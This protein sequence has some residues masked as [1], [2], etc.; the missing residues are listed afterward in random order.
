MEDGYRESAQSW[1]ESLLRIKSQGLGHA[2]KLTDGEGAPGFWKTLSKMFSQTIPQRCGVHNTANVL[3][4]VSKLEQP[5]M[6]PV[7]QEIWMAPTRKDAFNAFDVA[8]L[9]IRPVLQ[10]CLLVAALLWMVVQCGCVQSIYKATGETSHHLVI[11]GDPHLPGPNLAQKK[12]VLEKIN[13]WDDVEMVIAVGDICSEYGTNEEYAAAR[14][15][16]NILRKPLLPVAGNHD[17]LYMTPSWPGGGYMTGSRLSQEA[18]LSTFRETFGLANYYYSREVGGYLLVFLSTDHESYATGIS[19]P[20]LNWL[21]AKLASHSQMPTIIFF[22]GPLK[23]T[24]R[25]FKRYVNQPQAIAQPEEAIHT[26][27]TQNPQ[28]FLWVSG[29]THTPPTEE[30]YA[31]PLNIYAGQVTNIHNPDMKHETIWTNSLYLYPDRVE[32]RTFDHQKNNWL[33]R[34]DRTI[35]SP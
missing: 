25:N 28:V 26:L 5:E 13:S 3:N 30:S 6:K 32:I 31:S 16:F 17:Y 2:L 1:S 23:G 22:H 20:Q 24:Q 12:R 34:L 8:L 7:L 35:K 11:L 33:P 9:S 21:R 14:E 29:H 4:N 10:L 15:F 19:E 27:I 18:K